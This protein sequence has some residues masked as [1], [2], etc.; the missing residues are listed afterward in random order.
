MLYMRWAVPLALRG[1]YCV[2]AYAHG[3]KQKQTV[4]GKYKHG[5][6][7]MDG[8]ACMYGRGMCVRWREDAIW[9]KPPHHLGPAWPSRP[10]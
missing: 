3:D 1:W 6:S 2:G 4:A 10:L 8:G 7:D 5:K 9:R